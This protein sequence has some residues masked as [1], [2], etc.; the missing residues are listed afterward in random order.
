LS[1]VAKRY[2]KALFSLALEESNL[3]K[4]SVDLDQMTELDAQNDEFS[5]LLANP[6]INEKDKLSALQEIFSE[7]VEATTI[8]F[9][10]L[11]ADKK[12]IAFLPAI[13]Q[14]FKGMKLAHANQVQAELI[15]AV[16]LTTDQVNAIKNRIEEITGKVVLLT[17]KLDK[18]LLGGF[19]VKVEG[20]VLD[21]SIRYQLSKLREKLIARS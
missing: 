10:K 20:W 17:E 16:A 12:R 15:S 18:A 1:R 5:A 2:A 19:V 6:L 9:L 21:N 14:E 7:R 11:L 4:V 8:S 13:S 3:D